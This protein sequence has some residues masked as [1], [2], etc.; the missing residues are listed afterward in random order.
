MR[1]ISVVDL[2]FFWGGDL[3]IW[4][5]PPPRHHSYL[6]PDES[7]SRESEGAIYEENEVRE[8]AV[9]RGGVPM[10]SRGEMSG[11]EIFG[12]SKGDLF[13]STFFF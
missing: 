7:S 12:F 10:G 8:E 11:V 6:C 9:Y 5:H 4:G 3:R 1:L 2:F 13:P